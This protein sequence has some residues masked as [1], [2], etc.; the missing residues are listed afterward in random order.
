M[1][2][3]FNMYMLANHDQNIQSRFRLLKVCVC[4]KLELSKCRKLLFNFCKARLIE[5]Q[6]QLIEARV[7][8]FSAEFSNS[9]QVHLTCRVLCFAL[10]IKR[11]T[12]AVF[13][14]YCSCCLYCVCEFLVR[15]KR[16]LPSHILRVI[17]NQDL[18][19][20]LDDHLVAA[21]RD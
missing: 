9:T 5:N 2:Q 7:D 16:C 10:G 18:C 19:Q 14:C 17:K 20:E 1:Y 13:L 11:K 21:L 6:T 15:F 12:L 8:C 3:N 4:I